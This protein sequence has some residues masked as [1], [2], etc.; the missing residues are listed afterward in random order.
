MLITLLSKSFGILVCL[1]VDVDSFVENVYIYIR[2]VSFLR[3]WFKLVYGLFGQTNMH[4]TSTRFL[5][6]T[7]QEGITGTLAVKMFVRVACLWSKMPMFQRS[8]MREGGREGCHSH[9]LFNI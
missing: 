1:F 7:S 6:Q 8:G 9:Q 3:I 4:S 2:T 5:L